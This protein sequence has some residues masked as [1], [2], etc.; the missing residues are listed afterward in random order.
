MNAQELNEL[1]DRLKVGDYDCQQAASQL[2]HMA[3]VE[4]E[5]KQA[6]PTNW[7]AERKSH[8]LLLREAETEAADLK[9]QLAITHQKIQQWW[10]LL[11]HYHAAQAHA[12]MES[13]MRERGIPMERPK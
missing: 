11:K 4:A 1:S 13:F 7:E 5:L 9:Q 3:E 6:F 8:R 12:D 10:W 2:R